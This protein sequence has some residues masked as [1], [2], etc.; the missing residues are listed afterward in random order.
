MYT[1]TV[2][3]PVTPPPPSVVPLPIALRWGGKSLALHRRPIDLH[4][5]GA[6]IS[7]QRDAAARKEDP[8]ADHRARLNSDSIHLPPD[9][10]PLEGAGKCILS[11]FMVRSPLH[12]LRWSPS[13]SLCDGEANHSHFIAGRYT[14]MA[15]VP[16]FP[17]SVMPPP[18]RK[19][20]PPI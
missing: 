17:P 13:P 8:A 4:G 14:C 18:G 10:Q 15:L 9:G 16:E 1:V 2:Y 20:R 6:A 12:H 11:L 5:V 3:G 19:I 7:A